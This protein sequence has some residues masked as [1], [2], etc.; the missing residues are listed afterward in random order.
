MSAAL[1]FRN[2]DA[3]VNDLRGWVEQVRADAADAAAGLAYTALREVAQMSAQY[4]GDFAANWKL[5]VGSPDYSFQ[6]QLFS[7]AHGPR[8]MG[9]AQ[10][11]D[12]A[13]DHAR[14]KLAGMKLGDTLY[15]ANSAAHD[16]AY[17]WKIEDNRIKFR[18]GNKGAPLRT[19]EAQASVKYAN[20]TPA[21]FEH[22]VQVGRAA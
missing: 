21:V 4:S 8:I 17:A 18:P 12:Y 19:W 13:L 2:L 7:L 10:A 3:F 16:E 1:E 6:G 5:A 22:L 14:G 20:L 9:D 11:I 15:L